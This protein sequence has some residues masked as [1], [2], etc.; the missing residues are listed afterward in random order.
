MFVEIYLSDQ[1]PPSAS[2]RQI[3]LSPTVKCKLTLS[4]NLYTSVLSYPAYVGLFH[5]SYEF[6][7][8]C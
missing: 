1:F 3:N 2:Y 8:M 7:R 6:M 5:L 4:E